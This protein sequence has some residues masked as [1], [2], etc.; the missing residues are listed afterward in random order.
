MKFE[1][2]SLKSGLLDG[3]G[4]KDMLNNTYYEADEVASELEKIKRR[5]DSLKRENDM[6]RR[7]LSGLKSTGFQRIF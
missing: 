5:N 6:I 7:E 1:N 4:S 2:K 3:E